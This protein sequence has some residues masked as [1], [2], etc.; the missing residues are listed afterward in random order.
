MPCPRL[1]QGTGGDR[2]RDRKEE[3]T[4]QKR[5]AE[6]RP[7]LSPHHAW[8]RF[9]IPQCPPAPGPRLTAGLWA[10]LEG[11][12]RVPGEGDSILSEKDRTPPTATQ[13]PPWERT[14]PQGAEP[15]LGPQWGKCW[16]LPCAPTL[17]GRGGLERGPPTL[18]LHD[19]HPRS[20]ATLGR[21]RR[22][23]GW[24]AVGVLQ[25]GSPHPWPRVLRQGAELLSQ[26]GAWPGARPRAL[27]QGAGAAAVSRIPCCPL[28]PSTAPASRA[29]T[30][31]HGPLAPRPMPVVL[32]A[33]RG[34]G[35]QGHWSP[36]VGMLPPAPHP[37]WGR[38]RS[39]A[40]PGGHRAPP[41]RCRGSPATSDSG[42]ALVGGPAGQSGRAQGQAV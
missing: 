41:E 39:R 13:L 24:G 21:D 16:G 3:G 14:P 22:G 4:G 32:S 33:P 11:D 29:T 10:V 23:L 17:T 5:G 42:S 38:G 15:N 20:R 9:A 8:G 31:H 26:A 1:H 34:S 7:F 36:S 19:P 28:D 6:P 18:S 12:D 40:L 25:R 27:A 35:W 30:G 2:G 37:W